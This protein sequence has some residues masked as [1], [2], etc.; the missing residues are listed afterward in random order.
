MRPV[1]R[2]RKNAAGQQSYFQ[3]A[4]RDARR[5]PAERRG[6]HYGAQAHGRQLGGARQ[7]VVGSAFSRRIS[8]AAR[9]CRP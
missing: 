7:S 9:A 1:T 4:L 3:V 2:G 6:L 8:A 5:L